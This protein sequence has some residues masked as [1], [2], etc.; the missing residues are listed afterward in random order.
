MKC[1][2]SSA[3]RLITWNRVIRTFNTPVS[4]QEWVTYVDTLSANCSSGN[5]VSAS[6][7]L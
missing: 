3:G 7:S 4:A 1:S 5:R 2:Q 6:F